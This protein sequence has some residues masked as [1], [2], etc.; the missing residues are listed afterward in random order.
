MTDEEKRKKEYKQMFANTEVAPAFTET[1]RVYLI[2]NLI[3][4]LDVKKQTAQA[5][6]YKTT[7]KAAAEWER[8]RQGAEADDTKRFQVKSDDLTQFISILEM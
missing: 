5:T 1:Q 2:G 6:E 3:V 4:D 8:L 7:K